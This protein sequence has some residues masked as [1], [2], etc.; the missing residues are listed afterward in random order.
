MLERRKEIIKTQS[1]TSLLDSNL[2]NTLKSESNDKTNKHRK[3]TFIFSNNNNDK[4]NSKKFRLSKINSDNL[5]KFLKQK[6]LST[7]KHKPLTDNNLKK[8]NSIYSNKNY[9]TI[10]AS[11][12]N[13]SKINS[14]KNIKRIKSNSKLAEIKSLSSSP[15]NM[16]SNSPVIIYLPL[17]NFEKNLPSFE[18]SEEDRMFNQYEEEKNSKPK[19]KVTKIKSKEKQK[20]KT[21]KKKI[22]PASVVAL[23]KVYKKIPKIIH[24]IENL[25]KLKY[26]MSLHKYQKLLLKTGSKTLTKESKDKLSDKFKVIRKTSEK[27]YD[28]FKKSL[29]S[30]EKQEKKIIDKINKQQIFFKKTLSQQPSSFYSTFSNFDFLPQIKFYR[31]PKNK[32]K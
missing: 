17:S 3:M 13:N 26:S 9:E 18:I 27:S 31:T 12:N 21:T 4:S 19:K 11:K 1:K 6:S 8:K 20:Q 24:E 15:K 16:N 5:K 14:F 28:L 29:R 23:H 25:K 30:I 22:L 10:D 7:N 2:T 32:L